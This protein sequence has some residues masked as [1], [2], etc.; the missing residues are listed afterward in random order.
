MTGIRP[1]YFGPDDALFGVYHPAIGPSREHAVLIAPPPM[2][3]NLR[4]HFALRLMALTLAESGHDV[5]RFDYFGTGSSK[6]DIR[7]AS[8]SE[9]S[10]NLS[11]AADELES[12]CNATKMSVV[13][14]RFAARLATALT[15]RRRIRS[16]VLWDPV[17][18]GGDWLRSL[19]RGQQ[20]FEG[21]FSHKVPI[22]DHEIMGY[23]TNPSFEDELAALHAVEIESDYSFALITD[24]Y[25][26]EEQLRQSVDTVER[27]NYDCG[28]EKME[29]PLLHKHEIIEMTCQAIS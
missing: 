21:L 25:R 10:N 13:A 19:H 6:S 16:L 18:D 14:V 26:Y 2:N 9:W 29:M 27:I 22:D 1:F 8:V 15:A 20:D 11:A 24:D 28:W 12:H 4:S 5:L 23:I 17:L 3:E 7:S